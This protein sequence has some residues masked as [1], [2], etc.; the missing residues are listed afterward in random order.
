V[1]VAVDDLFNKGLLRLLLLKICCFALAISQRAACSNF[2]QND[3]SKHRC[4]VNQVQQKCKFIGKYL[5]N[6]GIYTER[7]AIQEMK[8]LLAAL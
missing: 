2:A 6:I 8:D 1:T 3:V 5:K 7:Q 4:Q